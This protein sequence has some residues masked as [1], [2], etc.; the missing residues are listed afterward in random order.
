M[1]NRRI[2]EDAVTEIEDQGALPPVF[3]YQINGLVKRLA[4][5]A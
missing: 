1:G 5:G 2:G 4:A 3:Q